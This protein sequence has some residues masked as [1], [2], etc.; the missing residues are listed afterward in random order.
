MNDK[1]LIAYVE[2][3]MFRAMFEGCLM[4]DHLGDKINPAPWGVTFR[5]DAIARLLDMA[6]SASAK[7]AV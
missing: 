4:D 3:K 7:E 6:K 1:E 2:Q 5:A